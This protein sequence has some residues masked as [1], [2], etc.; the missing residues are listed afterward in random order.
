MKTPLP[1]LLAASLSLS[2][3]LT[4]PPAALPPPEVAK[5]GY[6]VFVGLGPR[7]EERL[8]EAAA[9]Q[10]E[11]THP[12]QRYL[13]LFEQRIHGEDGFGQRLTSAL[14]RDGYFI[15]QWYDPAMPP[16]CGETA[17]GG[18]GETYRAVPVCYLLDSVGEMLRL[19]L[20]A[21][22]ETWSRLFSAEADDTLRPLGAW[23]QHQA[24]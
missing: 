14:Q 13:L 6:G 10:L 18:G 15:R 19:T 1:L 17:G 12:P 3:C 20:Y 4:T 24:R 7:L 21:A 8:A 5:T 9:G 23:T 2:A 22:G 16:Q 11:R